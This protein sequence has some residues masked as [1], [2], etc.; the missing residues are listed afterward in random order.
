MRVF[1]SLG[2]IE[3]FLLLGPAL[4]WCVNAEIGLQLALL[5]MF[6]GSTNSIFKIAF[7]QPRPTW[8]NPGVTPYI[9]ETSFGIPS[10]H[11]QHAIVVWGFLD[12]RL[13]KFWGWIVAVVLTL[14]IGLSRVVLGVHFPSDLIGG[15]FIGL[16]ILWLF[17]KFLPPLSAYLKRL[18]PWFQVGLAF[19]ASLA[20]L[21]TGFGVRAS[22]GGWT[23][24]QEWIS[25]AQIA[26]PG[27]D[28]ITPLD[29]S[30]LVS[31]AGLFFGLA[32][33]A[34]LVAWK[35]GFSPK[36]KISQRILRYLVGL[37][38]VL[39][40]WRGLDIV[41]PSGDQ[42]IPMVLRYLRYGL[43]GLWVTGLAPLIF[44]LLK[45]IPPRD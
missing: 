26:N 24:P 31:N 20:I 21:L 16:L 12:I 25:N 23:V 40:L 42:L 3:F 27:S 32:A 22:L 15:W 1:T 36:G 29:M 35:G 2:T 13:R 19:A 45:L 8:L 6:S 11:A 43:V 10:G 41:L 33:G 38:G 14:L 17:I 7:H 28:P 39:V 4:Y 9:T 37:I 44:R 5:L 30:G 34:V 18:R